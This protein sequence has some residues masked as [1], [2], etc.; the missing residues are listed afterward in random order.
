MK[1]IRLSHTHVAK[2]NSTSLLKMCNIRNK[3][4]HYFRI[5]CFKKNLVKDRYFA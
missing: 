4:F 2:N 5:V 1:Y 3:H